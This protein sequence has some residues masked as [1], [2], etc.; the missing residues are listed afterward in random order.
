MQCEPD[1]RLKATDELFD[2]YVVVNV[3]EAQTEP[4][5]TRWF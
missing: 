1:D 2:P 5:E 3:M 4:G